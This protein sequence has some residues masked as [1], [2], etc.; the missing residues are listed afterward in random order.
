MVVMVVVMVMAVMAISRP[1]ACCIGG[2][3]TTTS[4]AVGLGRCSHHQVDH[5]FMDIIIS[6]LFVILKNSST[7]DES[8]LVSWDADRC[9]YPLLKLFNSNIIRNGV[10]MVLGIQSLD[11]NVNHFGG[12]SELYPVK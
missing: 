5:F 1:A 4:A 6:Q 11:C 12:D 10:P 2:S 9:H 8:L 3:S 7:V